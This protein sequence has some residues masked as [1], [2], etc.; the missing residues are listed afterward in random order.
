MNRPVICGNCGGK[1]HNRRSCK[2][3]APKDA[4]QLLP[5]QV[6]VGNTFWAPYGK[7]GW[8]AVRI[9]ETGRVWGKAERVKPKTG[10]VVNRSGRVRLDELLLRDPSVGGVDRP[11]KTPELVFGAQ[12]ESRLAAKVADGVRAAAVLAPPAPVGAPQ[13]PKPAP[14]PSRTPEE[15]KATQAR[16][17]ALFDLLDDGSTD[18]DW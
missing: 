9:L 5:W 6:Q 14:T 7:K 4:R 13:A 1:D 2:K 10:E 16:L 18:D 3:A 15:E 11:E 8:S 12:R 17:S